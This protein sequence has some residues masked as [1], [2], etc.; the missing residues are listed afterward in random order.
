M[1]GYTSDFGG[2]QV[3][4]VYSNFRAYPAYRY[5]LFL[6]SHDGQSASVE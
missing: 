6:G 5:A 4:V 2:S 1:T 3:F